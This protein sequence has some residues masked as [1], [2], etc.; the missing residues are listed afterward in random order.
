MEDK[1]KITV[2][3]TGFE[4]RFGESYESDQ[5]E[6]EWAQPARRP[7]LE[8]EVF[9]RSFAEQPKVEEDSDILDVPAFLR[10]QME[11]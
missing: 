2:I 7:V 3:A 9:D 10:H 4:A 8:E 11:G 1:L 6:T 5:K